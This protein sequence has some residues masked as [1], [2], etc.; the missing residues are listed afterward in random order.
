MIFNE[1]KKLF[2]ADK[3]G[4]NFYCP[5]SARRQR[6]SDKRITKRKQRRYNKKLIRE[7]LEDSEC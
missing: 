4:W 7:E 2:R 6:K 3:F 1:W 5:N